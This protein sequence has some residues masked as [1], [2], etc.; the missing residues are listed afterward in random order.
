M[1]VSWTFDF[2]RKKNFEIIFWQSKIAP[3][4]VKTSL[5]M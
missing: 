3:N 1:L 4:A 5:H 2:G